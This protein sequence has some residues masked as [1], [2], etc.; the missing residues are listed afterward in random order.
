MPKKSRKDATLLRFTI[1]PAGESRTE[2]Q[3]RKDVEEALSEALEKYNSKAKNKLKAEAEPEGAFTG[4]ELVAFWLLKTFAG[5]VVGGV[6][7]AAGKK[8]Y[9]LFASALKERNLAP[10]KPAVVKPQTKGK[11]KKNS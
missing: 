3:V 2:K 10:G 9:G 8:L 6:G 7:A 5:G 4:V 1:K 11:G